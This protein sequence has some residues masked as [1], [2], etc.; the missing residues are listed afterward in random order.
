MTL[1]LYFKFI[2][3][4]IIASILVYLIQTPLK[5]I[6]NRFLLAFLFIIKVL[7]TIWL[8]LLLI[9]FGPTIIWRHEYVFCALYLA[10]TSSV[11][12]DIV[13]FIYY[14]IKK[15]ELKTNLK[16][17]I[18]ALLTILF[19]TYNIINMQTIKADYHQISSSKI[20]NNYR[21]VFFSDL[22]YGSSQSKKVVDDALDS[23]KELK[24]DYLLLGGDI[25]DEN[26]T[27]EEMEYLYQKIGSLNIPTYFIYGNHDRQE[28]GIEK[29]GERKYSDSELQEA[30]STNNITILYESYEEIHDDLIFLGREDP[31]HPDMRKAVNNLPKLDYSRYIIVLD[32]TPYQNEEIVELKADLQLSGHTHAGQIFPVQTIYNLLKLNVCGDY[33]IGDTHLYVSPGIAGWGF[34]LRSESHC[35]YE[36]FDLTPKTN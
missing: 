7:L 9:A 21:L 1:G 12:F 22:H 19:T 25:T 30:L 18:F 32:H 16:I 27:K 11:F 20:K 8:A 2:I 23:I 3:Y 29:N 34:P 5:K 13:C 17:I 24:P 15:N 31:S 36:V 4:T 35:A 6:K 28:R 26:T 10:L 14:L 33:Y